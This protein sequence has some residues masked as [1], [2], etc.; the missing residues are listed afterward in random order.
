MN[1]SCLAINDMKPSVLR[2]KTTT[3]DGENL[4]PEEYIKHKL[5]ASR[6]EKKTH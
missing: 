3:R 4:T 1:M 5:K 2:R 6:V